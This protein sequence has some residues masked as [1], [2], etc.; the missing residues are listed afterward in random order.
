[1]VEVRADF[2]K[3]YKWFGATRQR[4]A[5][6]TTKKGSWLKMVPLFNENYDFL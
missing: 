5:V 3:L 2:R 4:N 1:M 6:P